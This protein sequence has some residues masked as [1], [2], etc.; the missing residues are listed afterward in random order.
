MSN[1]ENWEDRGYMN[2]PEPPVE[3]G[4]SYYNN[5]EC[6]ENSF[7]VDSIECIDGYKF[8]A[9]CSHIDEFSGEV[10]KV[11]VFCNYL[12]LEKD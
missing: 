12:S 6:C 9:I 1:Y 5:V 3:V 10:E 4:K 11:R 8:Y 2:P 7:I